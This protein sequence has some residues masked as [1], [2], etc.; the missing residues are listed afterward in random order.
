MLQQFESREAVKLILKQAE[1]KMMQ[2]CF[3]CRKCEDCNKFS[4]IEN[5]R[6][7]KCL[8]TFNKDVMN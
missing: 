7:V 1:S 3:Y 6:K 5:E 8:L 2:G 4:E